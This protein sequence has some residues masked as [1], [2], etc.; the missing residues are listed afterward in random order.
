ME[1]IFRSFLLFVKV[2]T[3]FRKQRAESVERE[4][5]F[6]QRGACWAKSGKFINENMNS[7]TSLFS[8]M[9]L[10]QRENKNS[11]SKSDTQIVQHSTISHPHETATFFES[12]MRFS[13]RKNLRGWE[14]RKRFEIMG[15]EA[16][17]FVGKNDTT[18]EVWGDRKRNVDGGIRKSRNFNDV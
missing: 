9:F 12:C 1:R 14:E 18:V 8:A 17:E 10:W 15:V 16:V 2:F 6:E 7:G 13:S 11:Q 5:E 3:V 4:R